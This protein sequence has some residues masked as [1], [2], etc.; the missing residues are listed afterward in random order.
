MW[1]M[2]PA[3]ITSRYI[4]AG[5]FQAVTLEI[6]CVNQNTYL[7]FSVFHIEELEELRN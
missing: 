1:N 5:I 4:P 7:C 3:G 6:F 2:E